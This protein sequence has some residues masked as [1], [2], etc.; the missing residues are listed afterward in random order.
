MRK[1]GIKMFAEHYQMRKILLT[2]IANQILKQGGMDLLNI[3]IKI[4]NTGEAMVLT[5]VT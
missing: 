1:N 2:G 4:L 5:Q 3:I